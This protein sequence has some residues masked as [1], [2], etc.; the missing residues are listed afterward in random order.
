MVPMLR[1]QDFV[2]PQCQAELRDDGASLACTACAAVYPVRYGIP[3]F[4]PGSDLSIYYDD[5]AEAAELAAR[6]ESL[7]YEALETLAFGKADTFQRAYRRAAEARGEDNWAEAERLAGGAPTPA[8]GSALDIGCGPGGN[9]VTLARRFDHA[10][11]VDVNF[12]LLILA[13]KRLMDRGLADKATVIAASAVQLPFRTGRFDFV[14]A[15]N[16]IEH[17]EDQRGMVADVHR[18]LARGGRFFFDSPN[19]FT[20]LPEP[21]VKIWG[22]GFVPRAWA[23][24]YVK[25]MGGSG[26]QG[27]RLLSLVEMRRMMRRHYGK[28]YVVG[29]PSFE[30]RTYFPEGKLKKLARQAYNGA[31]RRTPLVRTAL[32]PFVPTYHVLA[33]KPGDPVPS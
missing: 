2:C 11:G 4:R 29:I 20:L 22:V 13:R 18:V 12:K 28:G 31:F 30:E 3:D 1:V 17:V 8:L 33:T 21:H 6:A 14:T 24:G 32:F 19:R 9:L 27:K 16:V 10:Y 25:W 23:D 5:A 26:Y 15:M 7:D